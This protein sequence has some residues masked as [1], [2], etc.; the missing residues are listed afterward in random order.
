MATALDPALFRLKVR[1]SLDLDMK[2]KETWYP[3][4]T[5]ESQ[6]SKEQAIDR[7]QQEAVGEGIK[8]TPRAQ[9]TRSGRWR[10]DYT[11]GRRRCT[12]Y[13]VLI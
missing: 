1:T 5:G 7:G 4:D 3:E 9:V 6:G 11:L 12:V 8:G 2:D 10:K 13:W